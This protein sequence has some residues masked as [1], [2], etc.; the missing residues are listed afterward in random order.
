M[1][2]IWEQNINLE[3]KY[4]KMERAKVASIVHHVHVN[5]IFAISN[6]IMNQESNYKPQ[7]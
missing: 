2:Y 5:T 7:I 4:S 6:F 1:I 3:C